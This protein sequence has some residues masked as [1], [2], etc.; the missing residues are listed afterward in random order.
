MPDPKTHIRMW[1]RF[2]NTL[3]REL[4][5]E[6]KGAINVSLFLFRDPNSKSYKLGTIEQINALHD[7][8]D[9]LKDLAPYDPGPPS[10]GRTIP[11]R[12]SSPTQ[13]SSNQ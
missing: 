3:G 12:L 11:P 8:H 5:T 1:E 2:A 7:A 10:Y 4:T 13:D 9:E 6:E